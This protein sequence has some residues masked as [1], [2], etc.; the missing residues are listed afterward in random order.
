MGSSSLPLTFRLVRK[1][2]AVAKRSRCPPRSLSIGRSS[3][4]G[5]GWKSQRSFPCIQ[6]TTTVIAYSIA[7][8][9]LCLCLQ[10]IRKR[11]VGTVFLSLRQ[12][13][14][15]ENSRFNGCHRR[16]R[17]D[18]E[19]PWDQDGRLATRGMVSPDGSAGGLVLHEAL[20]QSINRYALPPRFLADSR[21]GLWRD[22]EAHANSSLLGITLLS[23]AALSALSRLPC[24]RDA[25]RKT[26]GPRYRLGLSRTSTGSASLPPC[27]IASSHSYHLD[28]PSA[29]GS[30]ARRGG[31][32]AG[33]EEVREP[34]EHAG[35]RRH[36][37]L[38]AWSKVV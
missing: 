18:G 15:M 10:P 35:G 32:Q 5:L 26:G 9:S 33:P 37:T 27:G 4:K 36:P 13:V 29:D 24:R 25:D 8:A 14:G 1:W 12:N 38:P 2:I 23:F 19:A 22:V 6:Y 11:G 16:C 28:S 21:F 31:L 7:T 30:G 17:G 3:L 20:Q 34:P